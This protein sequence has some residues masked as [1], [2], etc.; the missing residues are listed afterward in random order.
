VFG[1]ITDFI[2]LLFIYYTVK[3]FSL[4]FIVVGFNKIYRYIAVLVKIEEK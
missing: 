4:N 2:Y 3:G 1:Q